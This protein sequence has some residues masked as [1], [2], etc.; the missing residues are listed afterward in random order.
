MRATKRHDT[1]CFIDRPSAENFECPSERSVRFV[2][3]VQA[4]LRNAEKYKPKQKIDKSDIL[5]DKG[6]HFNFVSIVGP[7]CLWMDQGLESAKFI[8]KDVHVKIAK[9]EN[10]P[11]KRDEETDVWCATCKTAEVP[12]KPKA[13]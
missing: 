11:Q 12:P 7:V 3:L 2:F 13:K 9:K 6:L 4:R 1:E 5:I 8:R 10:P